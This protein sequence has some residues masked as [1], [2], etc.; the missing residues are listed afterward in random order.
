MYFVDAGMV[1][2]AIFTKPLS[3]ASNPLLAFDAKFS[4]GVFVR[5][6][7]Y[8]LV[9][10]GISFR[11]LADLYQRVYF[12]AGRGWVGSVLLMFFSE[13]IF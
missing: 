2:S 8:L 11:P 5:A 3:P 7:I 6:F 1:W 13:V 9:G 4:P 10:V 12:L